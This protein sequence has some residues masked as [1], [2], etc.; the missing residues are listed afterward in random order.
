M[1]TAVLNPMDRDQDGVIDTAMATVWANEFNSSSTPACQDTA[2][3]YRLELVDGVDDDSWEEDADSLVVGCANFGSKLVRLWV[4]SQPSGSVDYCDVALIVQTDFVGCI[5]PPNPDSPL[6]GDM[7]LE[8]ESQEVDRAGNVNVKT[9]N[10]GIQNGFGEE[11]FKLYQNQP[12]PFKE[13]TS[14]GFYLPNSGDATLTI[15]DMTGKVLKVVEGNY[16][17]GNHDIHIRAQDL[18]G[19]GVLYYQMETNKFTSTKKMIIIQ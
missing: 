11:V 18:G 12:N 8:S 17:K 4:I 19:S 1:L 14:I 6:K 15:F 3:E 10:R 7:E 13:E 9:E 16:H 5:G 2:L